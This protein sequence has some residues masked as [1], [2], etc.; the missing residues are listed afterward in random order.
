MLVAN[1]V[2]KAMRWQKPTWRAGEERVDCS[3]GRTGQQ[4]NQPQVKNRHAVAEASEEGSEREG[5]LSG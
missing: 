1:E 2:R 5:G 3:A 4:Q